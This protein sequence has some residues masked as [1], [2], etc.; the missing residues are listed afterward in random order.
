MKSLFAVAIGVAIGFLVANRIAGS[1]TDRTR[2]SRASVRARA[3][4][5]AVLAGYRTREAELRASGGVHA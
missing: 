2:P 3:F 5:D 1:S 4:A